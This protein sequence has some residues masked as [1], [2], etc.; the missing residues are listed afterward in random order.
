MKRLLNALLSMVLALS[1]FTSCSGD[2]APV[3][4]NENPFALNQQSAITFLLQN[5]QLN[6]DCF[7]IEYPI[8]LATYS[9]G[10]VIDQTFEIA[11][12][13]SLLAFLQGLGDGY[14][15]IQ[16]PFSFISAGGVTVDITGNQSL[17]DTFNAQVA[18]CG[19]CDTSNT[20]FRQAYEGQAGTEQFTMDT[21]THEYTFSVDTDGTVCSIGYMG[22]T[23]T[24]EYTIEIVAPDGSSVYTGQHVFSSTAIEYID[25]E[26][27]VSLTAGTHY[28]MR[29]SIPNYDNGWGVGTLKNTALPFISQGIT[30][31]ESRFYGGGGSPDPD[32]SRLPFIDFVFNPVQ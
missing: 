6:A 21:W 28:V 12:D 9:N 30:I 7:T 22:E 31:H 24:L 8:T 2:D 27:P 16:Y 14:Y 17:L 29:R 13:A 25:I 20:L 1:L 11:S 26:N 3:T 23:P 10:Y 19:A 32:F 15:A 18:A 4:V 5:I